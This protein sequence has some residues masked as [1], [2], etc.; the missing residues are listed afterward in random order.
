MILWQTL[1]RI[2]SGKFSNLVAS[3]TKSVHVSQYSSASSEVYMWLF[4]SCFSATTVFFSNT[5]ASA[6]P[7]TKEKKKFDCYNRFGL[8]SVAQF[9]VFCSD[10]FM[11]KNS[12]K[13]TA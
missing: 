1:F 3:P 2:F 12:N 5:A 4:D 11:K 10:W 7:L 13:C 8:D 6:T 9:Q